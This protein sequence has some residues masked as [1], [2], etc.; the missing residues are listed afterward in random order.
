MFVFMFLSFFFF[1]FLMIRR[2]LRSTLFPYTTL[3]R[4]RVRD[5]L[6]D[7]FHSSIAPS[8]VR[9]GSWYARQD[10]HRWSEWNRECQRS[11]AVRA[12]AGTFSGRSAPPKIDV[13]STRLSARTGRMVSGF[14]QVRVAIRRQSKE[15]YRTTECG[16]TAS[17]RHGNVCQSWHVHVWAGPAD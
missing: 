8:A 6:P 9:K 1:F 10:A 11:R 12:L 16:G 17:G 4:S 7:R 2:P 3:F 5:S 13:S 14:G 15:S